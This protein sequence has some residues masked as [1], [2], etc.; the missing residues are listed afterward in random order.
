MHDAHDS[1][2][3][4]KRLPPAFVSLQALLRAWFIKRYATIMVSR[5]QNL[6]GFNC[7][8]QFRVSDI[9]EMYQRVAFMDNEKTI[10]LTCE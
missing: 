9:P 4:T 2:D 6:V 8:Y 1:R 7:I 10:R 5:Q 3:R